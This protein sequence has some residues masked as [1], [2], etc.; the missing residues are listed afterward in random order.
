MVQQG[1]VVLA[2]LCAAAYT[3]WSLVPSRTR[4]TLLSRLDARLA[5][6][7]DAARSSGVLRARVVA[8]LLRRA[9]P[10]SGCASCGSDRPVATPPKSPDGSGR[11]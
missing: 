2:V 5:R 3:A 4:F 1:V 7:A 10:A 11:A 6:R 9:M 8:P